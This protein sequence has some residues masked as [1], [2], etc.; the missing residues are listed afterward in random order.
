MDRVVQACV[1]LLS[2]VAFG[3][4]A[5]TLEETPPE[6]P[7]DTAL[8]AYREGRYDDAIAVLVDPN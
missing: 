4:A 5:N 6:S 1:L 7:Y 2:L 8:A 3:A